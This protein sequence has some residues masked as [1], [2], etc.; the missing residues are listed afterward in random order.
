MQPQCARLDTAHA[1]AS[2][3]RTGPDN[4]NIVLNG[5]PACLCCGPTAIH[6]DCIRQRAPYNPMFNATGFLGAIERVVGSEMDGV[7]T[8]SFNTWVG[9]GLP[10]HMVGRVDPAAVTELVSMLSTVEQS[11]QN[12]L[13]QCFTC[14]CAANE[15]NL[16]QGIVAVGNA[17]CA[18]L[19]LQCSNA[20]CL[21][22][23]AVDSRTHCLLYNTSAA[24]LGSSSMQLMTYTYQV[25]ESLPVL[26][27]CCSVLTLS[28]CSTGCR[29]SGRRTAT[30]RGTGRRRACSMCR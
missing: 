9:G 2:P 22:L 30:R 15:R 8:V 1:R 12:C 17:W 6:P 25:R 7:Q 27:S 14:S 19:R 5:G 4:F 28:P 16:E 21:P 18:T 29:S 24:R 20:L 26:E 11:Q 23:P 3:R 13:V 10:P